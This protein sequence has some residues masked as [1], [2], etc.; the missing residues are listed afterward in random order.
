MNLT[1][2]NDRIQ[3]AMRQA[4]CPAQSQ[5]PEVRFRC[6]GEIYNTTVRLTDVHYSA[7]ENI[8][9]LSTDEDS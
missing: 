2:L 3:D 6:D 9:F 4:Q 1:E 8:L 5:P 7:K